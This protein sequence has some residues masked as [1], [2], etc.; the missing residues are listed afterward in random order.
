MYDLVRTTVELIPDLFFTI[1]SLYSPKVC[2]YNLLFK[3]QHCAPSVL[4][5]S[6]PSMSV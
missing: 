3:F 4:V 2:T 5:Y 1:E 6:T